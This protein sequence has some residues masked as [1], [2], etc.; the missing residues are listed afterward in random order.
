MIKRYITAVEV[1]NI[2]SVLARQI[3]T[4]RCFYG[5]PRGGVPIA[6][7]LAAMTGGTAVRDPV[8]AHIIVDDIYDSGKTAARYQTR[9]PDKPFLVAFDKR[10]PEYHSWLVMPWEMGEDKDES[11][12]DIVTRLLEYIGEN[13]NREGL[14]ET[15]ARFLKAWSEW[16]SG[17]K[18]NPDEILKTFEDGA[19]DEMVIVHNIPVISK[20]EHHLA[21]IAGLAHVGYIPDKRI[22]GLSKLARLVDVFARR[23]QVQ[24]RMTT[25][26]AEALECSPLKPRGVGVLIRAG[27]A[28]MSSRGVKIHGSLTTTSAMRGVFLANPETRAEFL[29]LC[30]DAEK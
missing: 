12:T 11:A 13:P 16:A 25:Q 26:I 9:F 17:Y 21:D 23:L 3:G 10:R 19:T 29:G 18:Q 30:R 14:R 5:V 28:C 24:E 4:A 1:L 8:E 20:C 6:L 27:H 15:P 22:V 7:T 2:C